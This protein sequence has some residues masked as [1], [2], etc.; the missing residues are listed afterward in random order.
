M[1]TVLAPCQLEKTLW[2]SS[3]MLRFDRMSEQNDFFIEE[4]T[5][6]LWVFWCVTLNNIA[7][8]LKKLRALSRRE[9]L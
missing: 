3:V 6:K 4:W 1:L 9:R 5:K 2:L 7:S 8:M